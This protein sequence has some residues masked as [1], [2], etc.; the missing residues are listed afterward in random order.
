MYDINFFP[1]SLFTHHWGHSI[2]EVIILYNTSKN[3]G[4]CY[5]VKNQNYTVQLL[6]SYY[7]GRELQLAFSLRAILGP[8]Y[9]DIPLPSILSIQLLQVPHYYSL[10]GYTPAQH[11]LHTAATGTTI[12]LY[13][14]M[15][16][17]KHTL[18][19]AATGTVR[20]LYRDIPCPAYSPYSCYRYRYYN[21]TLQG[22]TLAIVGH[23]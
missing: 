5:I 1:A 18:H 6:Y 13:R 20:L 12:L 14:D 3:L 8:F 11:T 10:Q 22:Y 19:T 2:L 16:P 9:R 17:A 23:S 4:C 21:T 7:T 15:P